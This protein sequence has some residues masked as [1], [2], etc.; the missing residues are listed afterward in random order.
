VFGQREVFC[1]RTRLMG[2]SVRAIAVFATAVA[3]AGTVADAAVAFASP[4]HDGEAVARSVSCLKPI[5]ARDL[6]AHVARG[7]RLVCAGAVVFGNVDLTPVETV[8]DVFACTGCTFKGRLDARHVVFERGVDVTGSTFDRGLGLKGARFQEP[9]LFGSTTVR[10]DGD[11]TFATF[12][13]VAVFDHAKFHANVDFASARF[14]AMA[15]FGHAGVSGDGTFRTASFAEDSVF[16][17]TNFSGDSDFAEATFAG[18]ADFRHAEF[19]R[20]VMFEGATFRAR[21]DFTDVGIQGTAKFDDARFGGDALFVQALLGQPKGPVPRADLEADELHLLAF[22][23]ASVGGTLNLNDAELFGE[24]QLGS[25]SARAISIERPGFDSAS[26]LSMDGVAT[27]S[28]SIR[29][30]YLRDY[31]GAEPEQRLDILRVLEAT[32]KADGDLG[33]ANEARF[34]IQLLESK[35]DPLL[36]R[37]ADAAL[38][39]T[40][41]GYF[42]QP[43]R[44]LAWL[45]VVI[46]GAALL[47]SAHQATRPVGKNQ[48]PKKRGRPDPS[49]SEYRLGRFGR[50]AREFPIALVYTITPGRN[51]T[52]PVRRFELTVYAALLGCFVVALANTNPTLREMVEGLL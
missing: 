30:A 23:G 4:G 37:I 35:D 44:P 41:A 34:R 40:V 43:L 33:R 11:L 1:L 9:A 16:A 47:R 19:G 27:R 42:V 5:A 6:V 8:R 48:Q 7:G 20:K 26:V 31:L 12:N 29:P 51:D 14:R 28:L 2:M 21:A 52:P 24:V 39:R 25:V 3:V 15:R 17:D 10:A 50:A 45:L 18:P 46:V 38:Y 32:A 22:S 36:Q 13:D 49:V